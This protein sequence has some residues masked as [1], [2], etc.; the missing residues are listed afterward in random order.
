MVGTLSVFIF[1]LTQDLKKS[2]LQSQQSALFNLIKPETDTQH[3]KQSEYAQD[4]A[5]PSQFSPAND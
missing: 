2:R 3:P 4:F 1:P 5:D